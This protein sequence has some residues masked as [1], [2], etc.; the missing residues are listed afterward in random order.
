MHALDPR[1][2]NIDPLL[3]VAVD[4]ADGVDDDD[5]GVQVIVVTLLMSSMSLSEQLQIN[6]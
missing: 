2:Q 4:D 1:A 5:L 3:G 6:Q